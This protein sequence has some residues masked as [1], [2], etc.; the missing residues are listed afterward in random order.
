MSAGHDGESHEQLKRWAGEPAIA[1]V[2][3]RLI[4][5]VDRQPMAQRERPPQVRLKADKTPV[6]F[7]TSKTPDREFAW[8]LLEAIAGRGWIELRLPKRRPANIAPFDAEP[9]IV[10]TPAGEFVI[11]KALGRPV[12][13]RSDRDLWKEALGRLRLPEERLSGF[14]HQPVKVV[15]RPAVD[16]AGRLALLPGLDR[17]L[18]LREASATVFW[19]ISKLL[20]TRR[21]AVTR[22]LDDPEAFPEKPVLINV[23]VPGPTWKGLLLIENETTYHS[24]VRGRLP[25][26]D[27]A[28]LAVAWISGFMGTAKRLRS[29]EGVSI[30][31]S[32]ASDPRGLKR[33]ARAWMDPACQLLTWFFGDLDFAAMDILRALREIFVGTRAWEPGYRVL[34]DRARRGEGHAADEDVHKGGQQAG[35]SETGCPF[36]DTQLL[37]FL[38]RSG[39]FVDQEAYVAT[40]QMNI[41]N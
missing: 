13:G 32:L 38:R 6:F 19:G 29:A 30:H 16:V 8:S 7:D 40:R 14:L 26:V 20:D 39:C 5:L 4:D 9:R 31:A 41:D 34:L 24:A 36:A 23:H 12:N 10:L 37:P 18:Y 27:P 33:L 11:R 17:S 25:D 3:H 28:R 22:L 35:V 1:E 15:G 21:E 2:L